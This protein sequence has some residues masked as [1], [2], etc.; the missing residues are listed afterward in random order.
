MT[1]GKESAVKPS[2]GENKSPFLAEPTSADFGES[3][4]SLFAA[5]DVLVT[6]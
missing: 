5:P 1:L 2:T 3:S 4:N 6:T